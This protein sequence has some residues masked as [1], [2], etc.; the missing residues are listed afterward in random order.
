MMRT[1]WISLLAL[2]ACGDN[3]LVTAP[4][5]PMPSAPVEGV[6][7]GRVPQPACMTRYS[8]G[9][10]APLECRLSLVDGDATHYITTC[11]IDPSYVGLNY[12][13]PPVTDE[14]Q[15]TPSGMLQHEVTQFLGSVS[16]NYQDATYTYD[17]SGQ[18]IEALAVDRNG[19]T[20]FDSVVTQRSADGQPAAIAI[21]ES[22]LEFEG[23]TYPATAHRSVDLT[24][25]SN[26]RLIESVD[27]FQPS[28]TIF[29]DTSITYDDAALRR[30][31]A[32]YSDLQALVPDAGPPGTLHAFDI[33]DA[34]GN[35]LER[36]SDDGD[37]DAS[38]VFIY[39]DQDRVI[40]VSTSD[41]VFPSQTVDYI[42]DCP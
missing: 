22:P 32:D 39:D 40:E 35:V 30:A 34:N 21:T 36:G 28:G 20:T 31:Y 25:D 19:V 11:T 15:L 12:Y 18:M 5:S 29:F 17:D 8:L 37:G 2:A 1:I 23:I 38:T 6:Q 41:P 10:R 13:L 16:D 14:I 42:Y 24:Y 4:V 7:A 27:S 9:G 33:L 3:D 26:G